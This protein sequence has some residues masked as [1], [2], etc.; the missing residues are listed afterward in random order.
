M[1]WVGQEWAASTRWPFFTSHPEPELNATTGSGR[2]EEF[3]E[4]G[5]DVAEMI[6]PQD[7]AAY[8]A[9]ILNWEEPDLPGHRDVL[10]LYRRL[11]ALRATQPELRDPDLTRVRVDYDDDARWLVVVRG[12]LRVVANLGAEEQSVPLHATDVQLATAEHRVGTDEIALAGES[13]AIARAR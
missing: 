6:D 11:I 8:R 9:A 10:A 2:V 3:A 5:W 12:Q 13:A 7:P 1:L 4:H